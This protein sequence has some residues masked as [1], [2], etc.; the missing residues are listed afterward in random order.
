MNDKPRCPRCKR[1]LHLIESTGR[2]T[3]RCSNNHMIISLTNPPTV[4]Y[5]LRI[6]ENG[7]TSLTFVG[8]QA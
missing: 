5:Q 2:Y 1:P 8:R 7:S 4:Y 3:W 6:D